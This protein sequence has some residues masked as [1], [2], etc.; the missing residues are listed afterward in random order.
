MGIGYCDDC[1]VTA[2]H[3]V[4]CP[5]R[6][7]ASSGNLHKGFGVS[8]TNVVYDDPKQRVVMRYRCGWCGRP[9]QE[10]G[11]PIPLIEVGLIADIDQEYKDAE[12]VNG[13]CCG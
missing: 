2:D 4:G 10:D 6:G 11:T 9:T 5:R 12:K 7:P 13:G 3:E 1:G 8:E